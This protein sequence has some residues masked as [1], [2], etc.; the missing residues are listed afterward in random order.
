MAAWRAPWGSPQW[1]RHTFITHT[2]AFNQSIWD[3]LTVNNTGVNEFHRVS[4]YWSL[5]CS[6]QSHVQTPGVVQEADAL[7]LIRTHTRQDDEIFL[8]ALEGIYAGY[9]HLLYGNKQTKK[10]MDKNML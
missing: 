7:V 1:S 8:S 4:E 2:R 9:F 10:H 6:G 5:L 3:E